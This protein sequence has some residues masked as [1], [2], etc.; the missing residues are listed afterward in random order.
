MLRHRICVL[1]SAT[2][3]TNIDLVRS[4]REAGLDAMLLSP[5]ETESRPEAGTVVLGRLDVLPSLDGVEPGLFALFLLERGGVRVLNR[6]SALIAVHDKLLTAHRLRSAGL[7]HPHTAGWRGDRKI[8]LKPPVVLKPRFGS[9]GRDVFLC[10][11]EEEVARVLVAVRDRPWFVRHG[12]LLQE[13]VPARRSDL[14]LVVAGGAVVG[15]G[16]RVAARGEWRTNI[17]LGGKLLPAN[18]SPAARSMAIAA[19]SAV[20]ADLVG[21]DL[22]PLEGDEYVVI[23]LNG[24]VEFDER[25]SLTERGVHLDVA[26]ALGLLP[27][28]AE[29]PAAAQRA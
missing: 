23:E 20:G 12:A 26:D 10:R 8:P 9:W 24:A 28:L 14:R 4:W 6:A 17:S 18:P 1:G 22:L 3:T 7:V 15:A 16:E 5:L 19:A 2:N 21:V 11:D 25:Y 27:G 29:V 13:L